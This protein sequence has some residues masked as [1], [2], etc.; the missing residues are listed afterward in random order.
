MTKGAELGTL[1]A[2]SG[3]NSH[4]TV[5][6]VRDTWSILEMKSLFLLRGWYWYII[7]PLVLPLGVLFWLRIMVPDDPD[8]NSRI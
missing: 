5:K 3:S 4:R 1:G 6:F 2:Y 8:I 7:R